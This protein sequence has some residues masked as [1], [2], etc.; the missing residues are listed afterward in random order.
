MDAIKL[1]FIF[2]LVMANGSAD[3]KEGIHEF[4]C[5]IFFSSKSFHSNK[6][7]STFNF[8]PSSTDVRPWLRDPKKRKD[9][10]LLC[11]ALALARRPPPVAS[12]TRLTPKETSLSQ[13]KKGARALHLHQAIPMRP[14]A[15]SLRAKNPESQRVKRLGRP[16]P[17]PCRSCRP[18]SLLSVSCLL[19]RGQSMEEKSR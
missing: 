5:G 11:K 1:G 18:L 9:Q 8:S 19:Q 4:I 15:R 14:E 12:P 10:T 16:L 13:R 2:S 17:L 3:V 6:W 7:E